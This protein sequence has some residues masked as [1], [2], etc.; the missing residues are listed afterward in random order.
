M[1]AYQ[2]AYTGEMRTVSPHL[3]L[4]LQ[5]TAPWQ[6]RIE[7]QTRR[8]VHL[9]DS[10]RVPAAAKSFTCQPAVC[11][12]LVRASRIDASSSSM[13]IS[14]D[15]AMRT[16]PCWRVCFT[17]RCTLQEECST[18][19]EGLLLYVGIG[20]LI[21]GDREGVLVGHLDEIDAGC[22]P[23]RAYA[24][25]YVPPLSGASAVRMASSKAV[26]LNGLSK[27][28][29]APACNAWARMASFPCAVIKIMGRRAWLERNCRCSSRPPT[30]GSRTSRSRHAVVCT[31]PD[32]RKASADVKP[33]ARQPTARRRLSRASRIDASSSTMAISGD[34]AMRTFLGLRVFSTGLC[35][36]QRRLTRGEEGRYHTLV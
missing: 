11:R 18:E 7:E 34:S 29:T 35:L 15:A 10:Q 30:P 19:E 36:L 25:P 28:A 6:P 4:A 13:A 21:P 26:S 12:R 31:C 22:C 8:R 20:G 16:S 14:G 9:P 23:H 5:A 27:K 3:P 17:G 33:S 1:P 32:W 2:H 24:L